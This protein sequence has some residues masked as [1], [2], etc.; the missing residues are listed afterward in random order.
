M[1]YPGVKLLLV[2][3]GT[4]RI[5]YYT[6]NFHGSVAGT[7]DVIV[8]AMTCDRTGSGDAITAGASVRGRGG[9]TNAS[10]WIELVVWFVAFYSSSTRGVAFVVINSL[11][12]ICLTTMST[13]PI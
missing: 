8:A 4:W 3:D 5:H 1:T 7:E 13:C 10:N 6:D 2:T 9:V 11:K 12:S